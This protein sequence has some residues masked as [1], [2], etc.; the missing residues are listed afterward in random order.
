M[1][2]NP[3]GRPRHP[4][5]LT[6]GEW[7]V[8]EQL[9]EGGTNAEIASRLGISADAVKY[10]ISNMLGKLEL[11]DR[12]ALAA[13]RPEGR[14]GGLLA[15]PAMLGVL[16]RSVAWVGGGAAV[17][18]GG[19]VVS[20]AAMLVIA[21]VATRQSDQTA[22]IEMPAAVTRQADPVGTPVIPVQATTSNPTAAPPP[23]STPAP[24]PTS[25]PTPTAT[26]TAAPTPEPRPTFPPP[27]PVTRP[28]DFRP[29]LRPD[30]EI[31][32]LGDTPDDV[33]WSVT[34]A[35]GRVVLFFE[36]RY[37]A[38][39]PDFTLYFSEQYQPVA[40]AYLDLYAKEPPLLEGEEGGWV[41]SYGGMAPDMFVVIAK[42]GRR[43][44]LLAHEYY[45]VLQHH[46]LLSRADGPRFAPGW[47]S[48]G[49]ASYGE[50]QYYTHRLKAFGLDLSPGAL[51]DWE[52]HVNDVPFV[53][54]MANNPPPDGSILETLVDAGVHPGYDTFVHA[55][56]H[57]DY[58]EIA[59]AA[60]AWLVAHSGN[61]RSHIEF[62]VS[63]A[64]TD[65]WRTSFVS[66][67]NITVD[68]FVEAF[69]AYRHER[70]AS[71]P[72][73]SGVVVGLDGAPVSDATLMIRQKGSRFPVLG[74]TGSDGT[75]AMDVP[76]GEYVLDL[77]G[78]NW[79][80]LPVDLD[81]G[82][83]NKCGALS[84]FQVGPGGRS[85]L[86]IRVFRDLL[87]ASTPPSCNEGRDG[88]VT[89]SGTVVGPNSEP[90]AGVRICGYSDLLGH[91]PACDETGPD[92]TFTIGVPI[93]DVWLQLD[94]GRGATAWYANGSW[95][96]YLSQRTTI[97]VGGDG[98]DGLSVRTFTVLSGQLIRPDGGPP[99]A[100]TM[101]VCAEHASPDVDTG[102]DPVSAASDWT[103]RL[104]VPVGAIT[105]RVLSGS[106]QVGWYSDGELVDNKDDRTFIEVGGADIEGIKIVVR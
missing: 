106:T 61:D 6:P 86:V 19:A 23:T 55:G 67:F 30:Q 4:D 29:E 74:V 49:S 102:C 71:V 105:L 37:N 53:T 90:E 13:W 63:L 8:L 27:D 73:L 101:M 45:H 91:T 88:F 43:E 69:D 44:R 64:E 20:V 57:P 81:T 79:Q 34:G 39:V 82:E 14:Q 47:L 104:A 48:E 41:T 94:R 52:T 16:G 59:G 103:F 11:R 21:V 75:F 25:T 5:V 2:R 26:P 24:T 65:D 32:F 38:V 1:E 87:S 60:I 36:E 9:R 68:E 98:I 100:R 31:V 92:G 89:L 22:V 10:H 76:E 12:R 18:G 15:L 96:P 97:Q 51:F 72:T 35:L 62:W 28:E 93:G 95:V 7:R 84:P 33:Q 56:V 54:V 83:V 78:T 66:T 3:R 40:S 77:I 17:A 70:R 58:Y 99:R 85:G 46:A 50:T 80:Y 42:P